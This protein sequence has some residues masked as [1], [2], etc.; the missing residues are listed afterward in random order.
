MENS[1][2]CKIVTPENFI[3]KHGTHDYVEDVT[4]YTNRRNIVTFFL[5]CPV[6]FSSSAN[7]KPEPRGRCLRFMAQMTWFSPRTVLLEL[8]RWVTSFG[9]MCP[10]HSPKWGVNRHFKPN[11]QNLK[12]AISPK[13][14]IRSVQNFMTKLTPST[15]RHGWSINAVHDI[16][17]G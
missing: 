1:T 5:S 12:I 17:H 4:Y 2:P 10:K 7:A 6:L 14:Y 13:P 9:K 3:L 11:W 8:G 15:T 16:Q